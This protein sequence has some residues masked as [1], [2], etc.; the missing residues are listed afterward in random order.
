MPNK[1]VGQDSVSQIRS[2]I[3]ELLR[4]LSWSLCHPHRDFLVLTSAHQDQYVLVSFYTS[5]CFVLV[6]SIM[7][8]FGTVEAEIFEI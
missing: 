2:F 4:H 1:G 7:G 3:H 5:Y 8:S 6:P